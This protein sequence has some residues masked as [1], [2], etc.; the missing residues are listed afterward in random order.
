MDNVGIVVESLD[1]AVE[2]FT[3]LGL[4]LEGPPER[5]DSYDANTGWPQP[6]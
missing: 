2:F 4:T 3:E 5:R 1:T 6:S